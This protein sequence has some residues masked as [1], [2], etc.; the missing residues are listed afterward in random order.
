LFEIAGK[1]LL[2]TY[3]CQESEAR[4]AITGFRKHDA[5]RLLFESKYPEIIEERK[6]Q[7]VVTAKP[8]LEF[9]KKELNKVLTALFTRPWGDESKF[10]AS[11]WAYHLLRISGDYWGKTYYFEVRPKDGELYIADSDRAQYRYKKPSAQSEIKGE[12]GFAYR[13]MSWDEWIQSLRTKKL[14]S[15]GTYNIGQD[16]LTFYGSADTA[17]YYANGFAPES[18]RPTLNKPGVVIAISNSLVSNH[19][20]NPK[21]P[22]GEFA[23]EGS[24]P[25]GVIARKWKLIPVMIKPGYVEALVDRYGKVREG[26]RGGLSIRHAAIEF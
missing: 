21:I 7:F 13:G 14:I 10:N 12:E 3:N 20:D 6:Q 9:D 8:G 16:G 4:I 5:G 19:N 2:I 25:L 11:R 24:L 1:E 15:A 26:S 23:H 17:E 18:F 22:A